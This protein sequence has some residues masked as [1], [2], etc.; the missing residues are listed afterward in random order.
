MTLT[1][2]LYQSTSFSKAVR[3]RQAL[4]RPSE[5]LFLHLYDGTKNGI[6]VNMHTGHIINIQLILT[7]LPP[8]SLS[9]EHRGEGLLSGPLPASVTLGGWVVLDAHQQVTTWLLDHPLDWQT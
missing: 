7:T 2:I 5:P 9:G 6:T 4:T 1:S 8:P 3:R